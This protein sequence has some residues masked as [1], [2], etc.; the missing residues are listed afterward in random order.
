M[1]QIIIEK[2]SVLRDWMKAMVD[3][4][5]T[6]ELPRVSHEEGFVT[7]DSLE[8]L[9]DLLVHHAGHLNLNDNAF[10]DPTFNP[11]NYNTMSLDKD[12]TITVQILP[13]LAE[14]PTAT[15]YLLQHPWWYELNDNIAQ[16]SSH[17]VRKQHLETTIVPFLTDLAEGIVEYDFSSRYS[18]DVDGS[19]MYDSLHPRESYRSFE[20]KTDDEFFHT[21]IQTVLYTQGLSWSGGNIGGLLKFVRYD[22]LRS[23]LDIFYMVPVTETD[24]STVYYDDP[25]TYNFMAFVSDAFQIKPS[26]RIRKLD[27]RESKYYRD[28]FQFIFYALKSYIL[29]QVSNERTERDAQIYREFVDRD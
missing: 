14:S 21:V 19:A 20:N 25:N 4:E 24:P 7:T 16:F 6:I 12:S 3:E 8:S 22:E 23:T 5:K 2:E 1:Q 17:Y 28:A 18:D 9:R 26:D 15:I 29:S 10:D 11:V 13:Y 27:I